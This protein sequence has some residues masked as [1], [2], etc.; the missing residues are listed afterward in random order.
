MASIRPTAEEIHAV[1][2]QGE[3]AVAAL[4]IGLID[5]L[6]ARIQALE[7][8]QKK[9]S[10]NS[11]KPPSSDGYKKPQPKSQ[12]GKSGK[13]SGGQVGHEGHTLKAVAIADEVVVHPVLSCEHCQADLR[14]TAVEAVEKRQVFELPPV[15]LVVSEHQAEV[16]RCRVCGQRSRGAFPAEV[17]Q[18]TQYGPR[19]RAQLVYFHSGQF[20]PLTRTAEMVE[21][22]YQQPVSEATIL[23]AVAEVAQQIAGS[24][25][26]LKT[27]LVKTEEAVHADE[28]GTRVNGKGHWAHAA[29]TTQATVYSIQPKRGGSGIDAAGILNQRQGWVVHDGWKPY[30]KYTMRHALCNAHHLRELTFINEQYQQQW[31]VH[32]R[33]EL[34]AIKAAVERAQQDGRKKLPLDQWAWFNQR[35]S[36][37]LDEAE[38]EIGASPP[39]SGRRRKNSPATNLLNRLRDNRQQVLAFMNNFSVPFDNNLAERDVRMVKVHHKVSGGFRQLA[40]AQTFFAVRSYLATARKNGQSILAV[41]TQALLGTPYCPPCARPF[42]AQSP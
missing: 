28:T 30:A 15:K 42:L 33:H 8:H 24:N 11:S 39:T 23:A 41:L 13:A 37:W 36:R 9:N 29:G 26:A 38:D 10:G 14:A 19:F 6:E 21:G 32:M 2:E 31:A 17:S 18:P 3:A 27:Y 20:I 16:K 40:S 22:L 4:V 34:C 1:Y 12:R 5:V 25:D 7:D 35:Y